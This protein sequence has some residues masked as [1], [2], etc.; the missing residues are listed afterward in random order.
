M[1]VYPN[2]GAIEF[3]NFNIVMYPRVP[4]SNHCLKEFEAFERNSKPVE[5]FKNMTQIFLK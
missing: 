3:N 2:G 1:T 5:K 4:Y